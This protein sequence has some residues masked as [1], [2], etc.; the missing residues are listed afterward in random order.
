MRKKITLEMRKKLGTG[1]T[2]STGCCSNC[3]GPQMRA[4]GMEI[5]HCIN[6]QCFHCIDYYSCEDVIDDIEEGGVNYSHKFLGEETDV[7]NNEQIALS[8]EEISE[9]YE[10]KYEIDNGN[11]YDELEEIVSHNVDGLAEVDTSMKY[12]SKQF[13]IDDEIDF[14]QETSV[15]SFAHNSMT[16]DFFLDGSSP[17]PVTEGFKSMSIESGMNYF[18]DEENDS[19][20]DNSLSY[21]PLG[22]DACDDYYGQIS[23]VNNSFVKKKAYAIDSD[24]DGIYMME[25]NN[26]DLMVKKMDETKDKLKYPPRRNRNDGGT[27]GDMVS[28]IDKLTAAAKAIKV[29]EDSSYCSL[30]QG[31]GNT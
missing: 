29:L 30:Q 27:D 1:W 7:F 15:H 28:L 12:I 6:K 22:D 13:L 20:S 31:T 17:I 2:L 21:K 8:R 3:K 24:D 19:I 14:S 16:K 18:D 10:Y 26:I 4:S 23:K 11:D 5:D 25:S 9:E